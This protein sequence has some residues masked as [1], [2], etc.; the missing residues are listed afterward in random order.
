MED[1]IKQTGIP[2]ATQENWMS[3]LQ[4]LNSNEPLNSN[5]EVITNQ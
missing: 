4:S 2:P 1:T 5:Q 3:H